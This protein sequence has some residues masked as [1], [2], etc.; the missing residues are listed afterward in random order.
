VLINFLLENQDIF[1]WKPSDMSVILR[2]V[3]KHNWDVLLGTKPVKQRLRRFDDERQKAIREE[4]A[5]LLVAGFIKEVFHP[6]WIANPVL[7]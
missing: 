6:E 3:T 2:E 1:A 7:V 4:I 5:W